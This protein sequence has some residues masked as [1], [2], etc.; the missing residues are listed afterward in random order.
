MGL[1]DMSS[2]VSIITTNGALVNYQNEE[3]LTFENQVNVYGRPGASVNCDVG[4][5]GSI[6]HN[7]VYQPL[8]FKTILKTDETTGL[9]SSCFQIRFTPPQTSSRTMQLTTLNVTAYDISDTGETASGSPSF[10]NGNRCCDAHY[11]DS[12]NL[13]YG[14]PCDG[15]T[16]CTLTI[17]VSDEVEDDKITKVCMQLDAD[18]K[19]VILGGDDDCNGRRKTVEITK[20]EISFKIV[21]TEHG[22]TR[23]TI[24]MPNSTYGDALIL[25]DGTNPPL[26]FVSLPPKI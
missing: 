12:Y 6:H 20:S 14:A 9:A 10:D 4:L 19:A 8:P 7:G 25:G 16:P 26:F 3:E 1:I 11:I 21:S 2:N 24:F 13:I 17:F 15:I 18:S 22:A 23:A 5:Y